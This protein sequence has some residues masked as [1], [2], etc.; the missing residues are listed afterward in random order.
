MGHIWKTDGT[1][2]LRPA[3]LL[4][5][6]RL[7]PL[8]NLQYHFFFIFLIIYFFI[9]FLLLVFIAF[10]YIY[11]Y[12]L[13]STSFI[14]LLFFTPLSSMIIVRISPVAYTAQETMI[15][16]SQHR[17][18]SM[19]PQL[20][21]TWCYGMPK[22]QSR[23]FQLIEVGSRAGSSAAAGWFVASSRSSLRGRCLCRLA[24][25]LPPHL[26]TPHPPLSPLP[27][28]IHLF[29]SSTIT[30]PNFSLLLLT[31]SLY[32]SSSSSSLIL[33]FLYF[34]SVSQRS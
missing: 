22:K 28:T 1:R 32:F 11:F 12:I 8:H 31:I 21:N 24:D 6:R 5:P 17:V 20:S 26:T 19:L 7:L 29:L 34:S 18:S 15:S 27:P 33:F 2:R 23:S 10:S 25:P 13:I 4:R 9:F 14:A 3:A 30:N 16:T